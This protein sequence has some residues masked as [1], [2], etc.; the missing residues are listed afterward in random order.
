MLAKNL[1]E[2]EYLYGHKA[3]PGCSLGIVG[4]LA[5]K[6][7]GE[8]TVIG[9]P[10]SCMST[11]T[12]QYPQMNYFVPSLTMGITAENVAEKYGITR[13]MQDEF[14]AWSQQKCEAARKAGKFDAEIVDVPV[15]VKKDTVMVI[16]GNLL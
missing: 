16:A 11:V 12:T 8:K 14:S 7:F 9:L 5:I 15:K 3:C 4:R 1:T 10:A 13:E 6:V 2:K